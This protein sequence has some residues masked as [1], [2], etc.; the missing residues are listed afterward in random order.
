[1]ATTIDSVL[2]AG[3]T[4]HGDEWSLTLDPRMS[5]LPDAA[6]GG[7]V[8]AAFHALTNGAGPL[9]VR[10]TYRRRV[11]L[12]TALRLTLTKDHGDTACRLFDD[13]GGVLVDGGV[14]PAS[15]TP[16]A[17]TRQGDA[18]DPLPLASTCLA[19]GVDNALGLK[20]QL[21]FDDERVWTRWTPRETAARNDGSLAPIALTTLL[22]E[23]AFWLGALASGE[24][25]MT[26]ELA[27]TIYREIAFGEPVVVTGARGR[28]RAREDG[29]YWDTEIAAADTSGEII[30]SARIVFVA[31]RGAARR[32]ITGFL[33]RST[34]EIL[35][36]IF[37]LYVC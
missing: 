5:G 11:P 25:G 26:T 22:D 7:T 30:A 2:R 23:A 12:G 9:H 14:R 6:H 8:L 29:R 4:A 3:L 19:C 37:P 21:L 10:G 18:G 16:P 13:T 17:P 36:R 27:V 15:D 31:V 33:S 20:A 1:M 24:S 28:T 35:R 32:L 34:P